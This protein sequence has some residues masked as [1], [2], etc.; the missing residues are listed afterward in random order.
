MFFAFLPLT[1]FL[2][3]AVSGLR[4]TAGSPC[5][6]VCGNTANTTGDEIVCNDYQYDSLPGSQFK[7]CVSCSL[8]SSYFNSKSEESD[9]KWGLYNLRYTFSSCV[10]GFPS[11][12]QSLSTPCQV[13]CE[14]LKEALELDLNKPTGRNMYDFCGMGAFADNIVTRC[15]ACYNYTEDE[16][17]LAN[18]T[19]FPPNQLE[20]PTA[21]NDISDVETIRQGCSAKVA[22]NIPFIIEPDK[23]FNA[24]LLE[25]RPSTAPAPP[26]GTVQKGVKN[27]IL[28]IVLP[29]LAFLL[30]LLGLCIGCI[31]CIHRRR[32]RAKRHSQPSHLHER[33]NDTSM[34]TPVHDQLRRS[35]GNPS[36]Y[37]PEFQAPYMEYQPADYAPGGGVQQDVKYPPEAHEM[38]TS[39]SSVT[40]PQF[41]TA[42]PT[43]ETTVPKL[44]PP[45]PP[46]K[47]M[48]KGGS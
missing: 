30:I 20:L 1:L 33:W 48:D 23:I 8:E 13:A 41:A 34:M 40:T 28:V 24:E 6:N 45:P 15:A 22:E 27:L 4:V 42:S 3:R 9:P 29:I 12:K 25:P 32:R 46:R 37:Q 21:N 39:P 10:Y 2:V 31:F 35:W 36:P 5:E 11:V 38:E 18:C 26:P 16:R 47:S 44:F 14:S 43:Q 7:D 17:L 19:H